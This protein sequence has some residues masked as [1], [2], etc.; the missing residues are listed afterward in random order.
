MVN[1]KS[2]P[3]T[4]KVTVKDSRF[5][6]PVYRTLSCPAEYVD[7][8]AIPGDGPVWKQT[9]WEDTQF[10]VSEIPMEMY[11][12]LKPDCDVLTV[13]IAPHTVQTVMAPIESKKKK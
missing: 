13:T 2:V 12:N 3:E 7:C 4:V 8:R 6:A 9:S 5:F 11:Q 1:T 10:G